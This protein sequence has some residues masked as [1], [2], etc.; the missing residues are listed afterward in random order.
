MQMYGCP[1]HQGVGDKGLIESLAYWK[2]HYSNQDFPLLPELFREEEHLPNLKN[3]NG[4]IA[5]CDSIASYAYDILKRGEMPLF[6]AGD[7]SSAMGSVSAS[8]TYIWEEKQEEIGLIWID[9]HPDINDEHGTV[10]GN[11]HG[12][13]V[14]ALLGRCTDKL[15]RFLTDRPKLRP[16]HIV[17][18]G[19]RDI[20]PPEQVIL[21][22][23]NIR[24]YTY[25]MICEKGLATCLQEVIRYLSPLC[26]VHISFD[27]DSM[28][29]EIMPGVSVP[30]P[31]G[32]TIP[33]VMQ[34]FDALF[35][36]LPVIAC[37]IVEYNRVHDKEDVT[38][39]FFAS[40]VNKLQ[41]LAK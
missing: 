25:D 20:D 14:N 10:T 21:D 38:A 29:P 22:E 6:L 15:T 12:M 4:V 11:I 23:L 39:R 37:D 8:S 7:H 13:P 33:D 30:V 26:A 1:M 34:I 18:F 16:E 9:A 17:M 3:L 35:P 41:E 32:F 24:Y 27:I 5:T 36:A 2:T 19:L 28:D 31:S 40:L